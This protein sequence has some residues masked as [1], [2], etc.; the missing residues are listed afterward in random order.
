MPKTPRC[1]P[2]KSNPRSVA[3]FVGTVAMSI[4][5]MVQY[6]SDALPVLV[7]NQSDRE[8]KPASATL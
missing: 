2:L 8:R 4:V 7:Q 6:H 1:L 5:E 3:H